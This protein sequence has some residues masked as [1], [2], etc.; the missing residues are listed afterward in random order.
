MST[1]FEHRNNPDSGRAKPLSALA[2]TLSSPRLN[3]KHLGLGFGATGAVFY[4]GCMITIATAPRDK[5]VVFFNS[6]LHGF[7]V[8]PI[9]VTTVPVGEVVLGLIITF[10]LG[11]FAGALIA[12]FYNLGLRTPGKVA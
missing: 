10:V 3:P 1:N 11:C 4:L 6:L 7:N 9:L 2:D 5:A 8:E 12:G